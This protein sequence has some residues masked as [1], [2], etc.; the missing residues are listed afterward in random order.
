MRTGT[1]GN[2]I[3]ADVVRGGN[4]ADSQ[5]QNKTAAIQSEV[6]VVIGVMQE[7]IDKAMKRGEKL[8]SLHNKTQSLEAGA[9]KF[10]KGATKVYNNMWWKLQ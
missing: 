4:T 3:P 9:A 6:N 8:E 10:K 7:N 2:N 5:V 1:N